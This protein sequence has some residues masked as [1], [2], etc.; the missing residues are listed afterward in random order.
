MSGVR[1]SDIFLGKLTKQLICFAKMAFK[2]APG[3][4]DVEYLSDLLNDV[5]LQDVSSL[6]TE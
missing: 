6:R 4:H 2:A 3:V 1:R 5:L